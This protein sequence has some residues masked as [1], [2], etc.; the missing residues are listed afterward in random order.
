MTDK[1]LTC[2][3]C[4]IPMEVGRMS[5][6][7]TPHPFVWTPIVPGRKGTFLVLGWGKWARPY[8]EANARIKASQEQIKNYRCPRCGFIELNA[9]PPSI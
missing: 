8:R 9:N 1:V 6:I 2:V 5:S 3:R 4:A 7:D